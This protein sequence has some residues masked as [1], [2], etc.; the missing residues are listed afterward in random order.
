MKYA[1]WDGVQWH[2][3]NVGRGQDG[4][5]TDL[6]LDNLGYPHIVHSRYMEMLMY[7]Y[8][9]GSAWQRKNIEYVEIGGCG[10]IQ[11]DNSGVPHIAYNICRIY[12]NPPWMCIE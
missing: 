12:D 3:E 9:D 10:S 1:Y 4:N 8:W 11:L 6:V 7:T 2:V 5:Y